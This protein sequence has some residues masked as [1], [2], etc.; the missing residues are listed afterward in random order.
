MTRSPVVGAKCDRP[1]LQGEVWSMHQ[2]QAVIAR[3]SIAEP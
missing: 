1:A 3:R 2:C